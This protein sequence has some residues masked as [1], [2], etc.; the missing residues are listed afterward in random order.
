MAS[1]SPG[2]STVEVDPPAQGAGQPDSDIDLDADTVTQRGAGSYDTHTTNLTEESI[3]G[4]QEGDLVADQYRIQRLIGQGGMGKVY[5]AQDEALDRPV[6]LK[7]IP[8]EILFDDD[9]RDD[10]RL[11]ANR[12]LDLAHDNIVRIHTYTDRRNKPDGPNAWPF[13]AME[14]LEGQTLKQLLRQ[15]KREGRRFDADELLV[16]ARQVGD[17]LAHAHARNVVHRDLKPANLMLAKQVE[18]VLQPSDTIKITDFGISRV[19]ADSTPVSYTHL[20]LP[21]NREV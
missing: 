15:R 6:A 14:Y 16:S 9:A 10:L 12:L 13:F 21:T 18:G 7:R 19:V 5:L 1:R 2:G 11:E 20:T 8:Q 3:Q 17:G 4:W